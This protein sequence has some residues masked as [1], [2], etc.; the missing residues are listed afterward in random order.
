MNNAPPLFICPCCGESHE[1]LPT[2]FAFKLPDEVAAIPMAERGQSVQASADLCRFGGRF[3]IRGV[4]PLPFKESDD[5]FG[6]GI[7]AEVTEP[8]FETYWNLY[9]LDASGEPAA[10]GLIANQIP[11]YGELIGEKL[12]I[13]FGDSTERPLFHLPPESTCQLAVEQREGI[14]G[15]RYHQILKQIGYEA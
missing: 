8:V 5:D 12:I 7:W 13:R 6:W 3:F 15:G 14:G 4:L 11:G 2:D 10:A 1:G 9:D